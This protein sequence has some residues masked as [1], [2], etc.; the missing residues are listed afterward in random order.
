MKSI[1]LLGVL[2]VTVAGF[3]LTRFGGPPE[4]GLAAAAIFAAIGLTLF[5]G[6]SRP[7][8]SPQSLTPATAPLSLHRGLRRLAPDSRGYQARPL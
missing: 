2:C 8:S 1:R 6:R 5:V 7:P 4:I 3:V